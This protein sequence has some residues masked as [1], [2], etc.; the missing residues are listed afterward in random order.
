MTMTPL[1]ASV[2]YSV[3][4]EGPFTISIDS[5]SSGLMSLTRL[6]LVPP[7][8]MLDEPVALSI[9]MPSM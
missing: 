3:D 7:I 9:R 6:G 8:P 4:A 5:I 2:P 1:T